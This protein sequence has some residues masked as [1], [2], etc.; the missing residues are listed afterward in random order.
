MSYA[1]INVVDNNCYATYAET[2]DG[3]MFISNA[4]SKDSTSY[5]VVINKNQVVASCKFL[6]TSGIYE[7]NAEVGDIVA[8]TLITD[9]GTFTDGIGQVVSA[10]NN[11]E[12]GTVGGNTTIK[13]WFK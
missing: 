13:C 8:C 12:N 10:A 5:K 11:T 4:A 2:V 7:K 3:N 6:D 9:D 1:E